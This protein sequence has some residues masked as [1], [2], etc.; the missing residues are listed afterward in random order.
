MAITDVHKEYQDNLPAWEADRDLFK[1]DITV[2]AAGVTYL[3]KITGDQTD[4]EYKA[5][6]ARGLYPG[7]VGRTVRGLVGSAMLKEPEI[8][9]TGR[10]EIGR[11]S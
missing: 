5:Y 8:S 10:M 7:A 3:P 4:P 9:L 11:A 6:N 1:G 2:K